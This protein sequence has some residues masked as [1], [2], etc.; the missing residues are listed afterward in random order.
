[1]EGN[2]RGNCKDTRGNGKWKANC[3]EMKGKRK[4]THAKLRGNKKNKQPGYAREKCWKMCAKSAWE[5]AK[6]CKQSTQG[7]HQTHSRKW[8]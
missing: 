1:M 7:T 8:I 6:M 2:A 3:R 5:D 4:E